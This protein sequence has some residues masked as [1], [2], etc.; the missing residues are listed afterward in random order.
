ML[1]V[2]LAFPKQM[3][4][5]VRGTESYTDRYVS[6]TREDYATRS[7]EDLA[8]EFLE[9]LNADPEWYALGYRNVVTGEEYFF[10]GDHYF[11]GGSLYK[12]PLNMYISE[13]IYLGNRSFEDRISGIPYR[14]VQEK[15]LTWSDNYYSRELL[16]ELGNWRQMRRLA[17][18]YMGADPEDQDYIGRH[19]MWTARQMT[20]CMAALAADP[21]RFPGCVDCLLAAAP[22]HFLEYAPVPYEI[23]QKYGNVKDATTQIMHVAGI[24][25]TEQ[26]IVVT[27]LTCNVGEQRYIMGGFCELCCHYTQYHATGSSDLVP[28]SGTED[29]PE[30]GAVKDKA[31]V[32]IK[33]RTAA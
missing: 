4:A 31:P 12:V 33:E 9:S 17:A 29:E 23:A 14:E 19:D 21:E 22:E 30:N 11:S 2:L 6:F 16:V 20:S 26:P 7:L 1:A 13:Q 28:A 15:S 18:P 5:G 10:N 32:Q 3:A 27:V 8:E 24:V 25:Y